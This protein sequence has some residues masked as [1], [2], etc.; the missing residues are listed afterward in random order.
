MPVRE[1]KVLLAYFNAASGTQQS[2]AYFSNGRAVYPQ[3]SENGADTV[4][5][6][7]VSNVY[8]LVYYP[9]GAPPDGTD[10]TPLLILDVLPSVS[11]VVFERGRLKVTARIYTPLA[12]EPAVWQSELRPSGSVLDYSKLSITMNYFLGTDL[13]FGRGADKLAQF[14]R[15]RDH[16]FELL[17]DGTPVRYRRLDGIPGFFHDGL[18][19]QGL[20][21]ALKLEL[22]ENG[23][24]ES[25]ITRYQCV[26]AL[27]VK[28]ADL[29]HDETPRP[30]YVLAFQLTSRGGPQFRLFETGTTPFDLDHDVP[31][32]WTLLHRPPIN[33]GPGNGGAA[34]AQHI[35]SSVLHLYNIPAKTTVEFWNQQ[36]DTYHDS[37]ARVSG[38]QAVSFLPRLG[39]RTHPNPVP[40]SAWVMTYQVIAF[41]DAFTAEDGDPPEDPDTGV[42][43]KGKAAFSSIPSGNP[44]N[45]YAFLT[46]LS[47]HLCKRPGIPGRPPLPPAYLPQVPDVAGASILLDFTPD[48]TVFPTT[49]TAEIDR[50]DQAELVYGIAI[51]KS[52][53]I[54]SKPSAESGSEGV[55]RM[56]S[57]D[58]AFGATE[59]VW[60]Q[61]QS[62]FVVRH[63][64]ALKVHVDAFFAITDV[65]PGGQD[66]PPGEEYV[67]DNSV[68]SG[69]NACAAL[70]FST[71]TQ[72]E[73]DAAALDN[74]IEASFRRQ[75]PLV[76][77]LDDAPT[78]T[79]HYALRAKE[80]VVPRQTRAI[81]LNVY[82]Q[83]P[84]PAPLTTDVCDTAGL[85]RA[86]ILDRSPFLVAEV[87]YP[88]FQGV[89]GNQSSVIATWDNTV[90]QGTA[91]MLQFQQQP[92]CLVMPPQGMGEEMVKST[93]SDRP[94][95]MN[96]A[97]PFRFSPPARLTVDARQQETSFAE[98]P[99]NLRRILG[100]PQD[101]LPGPMVNRMQYELLYG[102]S[103]DAAQPA[104][105][106]AELLAR[107]GQ[108]AGR[109]DPT[110][111]WPGTASQIG[112]YN[113]AR[114]D[115]AHVY[116]RYLSRIAVL[117]PWSGLINTT[118][119]SVALKDHLTCSIRPAADMANPITLEDHAGS[120]V[121]S[122]RGGVTWGFE[123]KNIYDQVLQQPASTNATL[124]S[125][126]LSSLGGWGKQHA[127]F[128][129]GLTK[130]YADVEM[131]RTSVY[132]LERLGRIAIW[133]TLA[134]H[135]IVYRRSVAPSRQFVSEQPNYFGVPVLRKV[136]EY[137]EILEDSRPYP[138][139]ITSLNVQ[140]LAAA[141]QARGPI[142]SI[143]LKKGMRFYV[144][145]AW[146]GDVSG[147][148]WA[149]WK[150]PL[151]S[152]GAW[153]PDVY[154]K[155][156]IGIG[157]FV[158]DSSTGAKQ[159]PVI[160]NPENLA[161]FT[162]TTYNGSSVPPILDPDP[163]NWAPIPSI[164]WINTP[165]P[166]A[167]SDFTNADP[168]QTVPQP[169]AM[170]PTFGPC[171]FRLAPGPVP[172]NLMA[173]R[174][175]KP[176]AAI[177]E[178]ITVVRAVAAASAPPLPP[179]AAAVQGVQN[180]VNALAGGLL[181]ALPRSGNL[182]DAL[183]KTVFDDLTSAATPLI[184]SLR[185]QIQ[186]A[187]TALAGVVAKFQ[188]TATNFETQLTA[189]FQ[190]DLTTAIQLFS[191]DYSDGVQQL[192]VAFDVNVARQFIQSQQ[193]RFEET[194]LFPGTKP[195]ALAAMVAKYVDA[196]LS[197]KQTV[198]AG[199]ATFQAAIA[200]WNT[201]KNAIIR[202]LN[203]TL[204]E[205]V[206]TVEALRTM[207][208]PL[209]TFP[210][211]YAWAA[212]TLDPI[213]NHIRS[214][215]DTFIASLNKVGADAAAE[216]TKFKNTSTF[217][218]AIA[219]S[220]PPKILEL[221]NAA[222]GGNPA[223]S[224]DVYKA[225]HKV[226][227]WIHGYPAVGTASKIVGQLELWDTQCQ[228]ILSRIQT[229]Q[230]L[231][232]SIATVQQYLSVTVN[233]AAQ[234]LVNDI[235]GQATSL[236]N[237]FT[238]EM[239]Q[240]E[241]QLT[242]AVTNV[243][244]LLKPVATTLGDLRTTL[245]QS[246]DALARQAEDYL[247]KTF[248]QCGVD[249][250]VFQTADSAFRLIRAFGA[251]PEVPNLN[252]ARDKLAYF[253]Q[254]IDPSVNLTPVLSLVAQ[255]G[256]TFD[257][258][259]TLG[260]TLPTLA[261]LD[262]LIPA[263]LQGFNLSDIFGNFA[264]LN[265]SNLFP[266]LT[267]P[268][269]STDAVK[270]TQDVD[271][272][273]LRA[274]VRADINFTLTDSSTL[275]TIGPVS[276]QVVGAT[277]HATVTMQ[278]DTSGIRRVASG[279]ISGDWHLVLSGTPFVMLNKTALNF[280]SS[281][282]IH[283][284]I[285]PKNIQLPGVL[286]LV[287][288]LLNDVVGKDSGLTIGLLPDGFQSIL[289]LPVPDIQGL[290]SGFS[291][292]RLGALF[293][294]EFADTFTMSVGFTLASRDAPFSLTIFVLGGGGYLDARAIY[295]PATNKIGCQ[296]N[297]AMTASASLAISL[298]VISG[299]VY[300]Y[301]GATASYST[302]A[303]GLTFG[304]MFLVRGEVSVLGIVSASIALL[305]EANYG[306]GTLTGHGQLSIKIKICWCF[307][308]EV[309]EGITYTLGT[310]TNQPTHA[311]ILP[312]GRGRLLAAELAR[313]HA[314]D[315]R[316]GGDD[317]RLGAGGPLDAWSDAQLD[318]VAAAA[319]DIFDTYAGEYVAMLV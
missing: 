22:P 294:I 280:D 98:A 208:P 242:Q 57:L 151:W 264:G 74:D 195:G 225:L 222:V 108:I 75:R 17:V 311:E 314:P 252:F 19:L 70:V 277:F 16:Q 18:V 299:G 140:Q 42:D 117:E 204:S 82:S 40:G 174:A 32:G 50:L 145:S 112:A 187:H 135:V 11:A 150:V 76:I 86:V 34:A 36:V 266:G 110:L 8:R 286:Q 126:S 291:N 289:N 199:L 175:A 234:T 13:V 125:F 189:K 131:A 122:L 115:W 227:V 183:D 159:P 81:K 307:T 156:S 46:P 226:D 143:L 173:D 179:I 211:L 190:S 295:T 309:N 201:R 134:K 170:P 213:V 276:V 97:L 89:S 231:S 121:H 240:M 247:D 14:L 191:K 87:Q 130:V 59:Q 56:G 210:N 232:A 49:A 90:P 257:S 202:D 223:S 265:L 9:L 73:A 180:Q 106:L 209:E 165:V 20:R 259:K 217:Y 285:N 83:S 167:P 316:D 142:G 109:R 24:A 248:H 164:D 147:K 279:T 244:N 7:P 218:Q 160:D 100:T 168:R 273:T 71:D 197:V 315:S 255:A 63:D 102:L 92:F 306:G 21:D 61:R 258:L 292:L 186:N 192:V 67:P 205:A 185:T 310:P 118:T 114:G 214:D 290:T 66:D 132:K 4:S 271:P 233:Q 141:K 263:K 111:A 229:A 254:E 30:Y 230:D 133:Y 51:F 116:R 193:R 72:N 238:A 253:F 302:G 182:G 278:A 200:D 91:W 37:L 181:R 129:S 268:D 52:G 69:A 297:M 184:Q 113:R 228:Q 153:P 120:S 94:D 245:E 77:H 293:A 166:S 304:V 251:A 154:P 250:S 317:G 296:V 215:R 68:V 319:D 269:L 138:D 300:V 26:R 152:P 107:V 23:P 84:Q 33:I 203:N 221:V 88:P 246:R 78:G 172:V 301:F 161:F 303:E 287:S 237:L 275:F 313:L 12:E 105:R 41:M 31:N 249:D 283:F 163:H 2:Q 137:V 25:G 96:P 136:E 80:D 308:L 144:D 139:T 267:L 176:M 101:P 162:L 239:T 27:F 282:G 318:A 124:E 178:S 169:S 43:V 272:Q 1:W 219:A 270:I 157:A 127:E 65:R 93:F 10:S 260:A 198:D 44:Q 155:P 99:W 62:W 64:P 119:V 28:A 103:C 104:F 220:Y 60:D 55:V 305:L 188:T 256:Q 196:M 241:S 146:G 194:L 298:A 284:S 79:R 15:D 29:W 148:N 48:A 235:T 224:D 216:L 274:I 95:P 171:T 261:T 53:A 212:S 39:S 45:T 3:G 47:L 5:F 312:P 206:A 177:L 262:Q 54:G 158:A 123:S 281:G 149:G 236:V 38:G 85:R 35:Q 6:A 128:L 207:R 243:E 58:L 288:D